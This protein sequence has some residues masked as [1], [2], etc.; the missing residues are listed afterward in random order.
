MGERTDR[1]FSFRLGD[2][3]ERA[4]RL[5][6][7]VRRRCLA[8]LEEESGVSETRWPPMVAVARERADRGGTKGTRG[9]SL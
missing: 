6:L 2:R 9:A 4:T 3:A 8:G 1:D 5:V 7:R